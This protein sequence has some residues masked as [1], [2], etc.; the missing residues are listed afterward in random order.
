MCHNS[1]AMHSTAP[2]LVHVL[3]SAM[4]HVSTSHIFEGA[5]ANCFPPLHCIAL[6]CRCAGASAPQGL[7]T[8]YNGHVASP[9]PPTSQRFK[10]LDTAMKAFA[11]TSGKAQTWGMHGAALAQC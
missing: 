3:K 4:L 9:L 6:H 11:N 2:P 10:L 1:G 5:L 8:L 7:F